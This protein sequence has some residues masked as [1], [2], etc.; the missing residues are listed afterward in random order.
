M[1]NLGKP[2]C[3]YSPEDFKPKITYTIRPNCTPEQLESIRSQVEF[4]H[5]SK[6]AAECLLAD[7]SVYFELESGDVVLPTFRG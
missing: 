1:E 4:R 5:N 6:I 3:T 7:G 2:V